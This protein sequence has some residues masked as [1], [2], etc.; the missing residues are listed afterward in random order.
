MPIQIREPRA[1]ESA[2]IV[3]R[4][5]VEDDVFE[6]VETSTAGA[7]GTLAE[8]EREKTLSPLK[9]TVLP[10]IL[11]E[12]QRSE[13]KSGLDGRSEL[14]YHCRSLSTHFPLASCRLGTVSATSSIY[15]SSPPSS[16]P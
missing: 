11:R 6:D 16:T 5:A 1:D 13:I 7:A 10:S 12:G 3:E 4:N 15:P 8:V 9:M 2:R 14:V